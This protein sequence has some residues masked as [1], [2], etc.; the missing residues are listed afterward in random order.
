MGDKKSVL[1]TG[2]GQ[3]IGKAIS[4]RL[5]KDGM[6]VGVQDI[7]LANAKQIAGEIKSNGGEAIAIPGNIAVPKDVDE[8]FEAVVKEYGHIDYLAANAGIYRNDML[9]DVSY[10]NWRKSMDVNMDG[11]FLCAQRGAVIMKKQG[12]GGKIML[13]L[14][15]GSYGQAEFAITYLTTKWA[16]RGLLRSLALAL[17]PYNI[18]VNG[19]GPGV[20]FTPMM[21]NIIA[22]YAKNFGCSYEDMY[23]Q[24][25]YN[26]NPLHRDIPTD[27]IAS[28]YSYI[29]SKDGDNITGLNIVDSAGQTYGD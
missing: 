9:R 7:N 2:G 6:C 11:L 22:E 18:T 26:S 12:K 23:K 3:G 17:A 15:Q 28:V 1:V 16:G 21:D 4:L 20:I 8:M 25:M 13:G 24:Q 27:E 10:E 19:V 14:S 29:F 5:A